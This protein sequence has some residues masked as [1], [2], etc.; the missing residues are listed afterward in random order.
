MIKS[1]HGV[2]HGQTI[3]LA[4]PI[5]VADGQEVEVTIKVVSTKRPW[6]E[7]LRSCAG[8]LTNDWTREDDRILADIQ[9][10]RSDD[11]GRDIVE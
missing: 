10:D 6:G 4:E 7:G 1:L 5:P 11:Q 9:R 3:E 8:A 2:V